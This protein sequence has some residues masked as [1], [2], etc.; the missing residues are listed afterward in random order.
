MASKPVRPD[1]GVAFLW[2]VLPGDSCGTQ[3]GTQAKN[4][5]IRGGIRT[6][7][8]LTAL[9]GRDLLDI[10]SLGL[11]CADEIRRVLR[12]CG[13]ALKGEEARNA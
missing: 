9:S 2:G 10:R 1:T 3:L 5:L 7:G 11:A 4:A 6:V 13:L 12:E 8:D